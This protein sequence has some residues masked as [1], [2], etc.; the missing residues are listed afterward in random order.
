MGEKKKTVVTASGSEQTAPEEL[1]P[2]IDTTVVEEE[3]QFSTDIK[4]L[5]YRIISGSVKSA[6][7]EILRAVIRDEFERLA[8]EENESTE[9]TLAFQEL[10]LSMC[11]LLLA[12]NNKKTLQKE[13]LVTRAAITILNG[14][15]VVQTWTRDDGKDVN[16]RQFTDLER[17]Q[18]F[19]FFA[20]LKFHLENS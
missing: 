2:P 3:K 17:T 19:Q 11:V 20:D 1:V 16:I 10:I 18:L 13:N 15:P 7:T 4:P 5:L 9:K 14:E 12:Q 8:N 6:D